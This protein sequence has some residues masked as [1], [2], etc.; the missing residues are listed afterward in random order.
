MSSRF[1]AVVRGFRD[2]VIRNVI[3]L[4]GMFFCIFFAFNVTQTFESKINGATGVAALGVLYVSFAV[5]S[6]FATW[7]IDKLGGARRA[8][9]AATFAFVL[10]LLANLY[11]VLP[12]L[13]P[14]SVLLGVGA[15]V[16]WTAH[17]AYLSA[18]G[19]SSTFG[20]YSGIFFAIFMAHLVLGNLFAA[21]FF[22]LAPVAADPDDKTAE[23]TFVAVLAAVC[24]LSIAFWW[25]LKDPAQ[26]KALPARA[27]A[28]R[29]A[30]DAADDAD[31]APL[32]AAADADA[33]PSK[34]AIL[35]RADS[36]SSA[37]ST[38]AAARA[39][40][41]DRLLAT[42]RVVRDRRM[43]FLLPVLIF[44]GTTQAFFYILAPARVAEK[45]QVGY[46]MVVYGVGEVVISLVAGPLGDKF[47]RGPLII[48][49]LV[50]AIVGA[51]GAIFYPQVPGGWLPYVC[52]FLFGASDTIS[53]T[54]LY[55][56]LPEMS[57]DADAGFAFWKLFQTLLLAI[58][59]FMSLGVPFEAIAGIFIALALIAIV[60]TVVLY[61]YIVRGAAAVKST[62][63][64]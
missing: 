27:P 40:T 37:S 4:G 48:A 31:N 36:S 45:D 9:L 23:R 54:Q 15:S 13:I 39:S 46:V 26:L 44:S 30:D 57:A 49:S 17:G 12:L 6:L 8:L 5:A 52:A 25:F 18:H 50:L 28:A 24:L 7:L 1:A 29:A 56:A 33:L 51:I 60:S 20:L 35:E 21:L 10:F 53:N 41:K 11:P 22:A 32:V 38:P 43:Q 61:K 19:D 3:R 16:L 63:T 64:S 47:G 42:V 55:G 62:T 58:F 59:L 2:P 34:D 14:A